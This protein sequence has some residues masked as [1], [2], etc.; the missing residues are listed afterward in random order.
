MLSD[1]CR[2]IDILCKYL[3]ALLLKNLNGSVDVVAGGHVAYGFNNHVDIRAEISGNITLYDDQ[4][5]IDC[6]R[7]SK[8]LNHRFSNSV[9]G[10]PAIGFRPGNL[11]F[12]VT[13]YVGAALNSISPTS[14]IMGRGLGESVAL[15]TDGRFSGGSG[16]VK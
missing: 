14:A 1:L 9:V 15:I 7:K 6:G 16:S 13:I 12:I 11:K 2:F 3:P 4:W 8:F 10:I 5:H